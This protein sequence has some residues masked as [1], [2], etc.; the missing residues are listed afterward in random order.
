GN[1]P[2]IA[3]SALDH[4]IDGG[5]LIKAH[6]V[7]TSIATDLG[8]LATEGGA[9]ASRPGVQP[10]PIAIRTV[11][12]EL[13]RGHRGKEHFEPGVHGTISTDIHVNGVVFASLDLNG[14]EDSLLVEIRCIYCS[15]TG[16][17][18]PTGP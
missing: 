1:A 7:S 14:L 9:A 3:A 5:V 15:G 16:I 18:G 17:K 4:Q 6:N 13:G 11:I 8:E 2:D 12:V 10:D